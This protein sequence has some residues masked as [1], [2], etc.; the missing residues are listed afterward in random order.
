MQG[1]FGRSGGPRWASGSS[2]AEY[3]QPVTAGSTISLLASFWWRSMPV[4][5]RDKGSCTSGTTAAVSLL[6]WAPASTQLVQISFFDSVFGYDTYR[7]RSVLASLV[8]CVPV[9]CF[10]CKVDA[11]PPVL[12][13]VSTFPSACLE[14]KTSTREKAET[15][16][17]L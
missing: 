17:V 3:T 4:T 13:L 7:Q 16:E 10:L 14:I 1:A 2:R 15:T 9:G 6:L 11:N 12:S 8:I 5:P